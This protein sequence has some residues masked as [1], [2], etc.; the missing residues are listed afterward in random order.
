MD[1]DALEQAVI[2]TDRA[3]RYAQDAFDR[4]LP[5]EE[6]RNRRAIALARTKLE[7]ARMWLEEA[8]NPRV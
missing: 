8:R 3:L 5:N 7:E 4:A 6:A 1:M 2:E